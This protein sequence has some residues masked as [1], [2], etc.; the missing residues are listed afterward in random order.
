M[1]PEEL[2]VRFSL[3]QKNY[4]S[5]FRDV[6]KKVKPVFALIHTLCEDNFYLKQAFVKLRLQSVTSFNGYISGKCCIPRVYELSQQMETRT[7]VYSTTLFQTSS[8]VCDVTARKWNICR[9]GTLLNRIVVIWSK[10]RVWEPNA[11]IHLAKPSLLNVTWNVRSRE[12]WFT[13]RVYTSK[14]N[15]SRIKTVNKTTVLQS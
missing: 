15:A 3:R 2:H 9:V 1:T 8:A 13:T 12:A 5:D 4:M 11:K 14:T 7:N 6:N 10:S